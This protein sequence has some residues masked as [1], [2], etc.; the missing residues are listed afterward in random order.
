MAS[1]QLAGVRESAPAYQPL[2][3]HTY[4]DTKY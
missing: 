1:K 2:N 4:L 3:E